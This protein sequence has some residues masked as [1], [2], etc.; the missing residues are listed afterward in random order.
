MLMPAARIASSENPLP[1]LRFG[2]MWAALDPH[3]PCCMDLAAKGGPGRG[4]YVRIR[5]KRGVRT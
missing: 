4:G 5:I 1:V 3:A 2:R